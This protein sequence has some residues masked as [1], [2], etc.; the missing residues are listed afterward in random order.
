MYC[1]FSSI[2][3]NLQGWVAGVANS[4][5]LRNQKSFVVVIVNIYFI[6]QSN[7]KYKDI[8]KI[9]KENYRRFYILTTYSSSYLCKCNIFS[10]CIFITHLKFF[11]IWFLTYLFKEEKTSQMLVFLSYDRIW[12]CVILYYIM[13]AFVSALKK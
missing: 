3:W 9:F 4:C 13:S 5:S 2:N 11:I 7:E 6:I 12:L 10:Y 8:W 1:F